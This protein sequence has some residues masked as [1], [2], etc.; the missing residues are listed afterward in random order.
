MKINKP[1]IRREISQKLFDEFERSGVEYTCAAVV[2][3]VVRETAMNEATKL[4]N[5]GINLS[6]GKYQFL[7]VDSMASMFIND[8]IKIVHQEWVK[9]N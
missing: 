3:R 1:K 6:N 9:G 2:D 5:S 4:L 7:W 8:C